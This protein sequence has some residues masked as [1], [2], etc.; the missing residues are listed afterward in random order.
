[1]SGS[2]LPVHPDGDGYECSDCRAKIPIGQE[3]IVAMRA[4]IERIERTDE[5]QTVTYRYEG[6]YHLDCFHG[7][8]G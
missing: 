1:M 2:G 4:E 7:R 3:A 6:I 8:G 5:P